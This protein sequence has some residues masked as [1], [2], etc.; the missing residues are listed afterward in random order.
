M[1]SAEDA[2]VGRI[3]FIT[4]SCVGDVVMSTPV[5]EAVHER[6]PGAR[7]DVVADSRASRLLARCP[8]LGDIIHKDKKALFR[9]VIGLM[10]QLR[11][12]RYDLIV[13]LRTDGLTWLLRSDYK[14][15]KRRTRPYGPH[16][17]ERM[18]GV[19]RSL[20]GEAPIPPAR[21]WLDDADRSDATE[22]LALLPQGAW[23][24]LGPGSAGA[25]ARKAWPAENYAALA[26][27]LQHRFAGVILAGG[28]GERDLA[29]EIA[30]HL[31]LPCIDATDTDLLQLAALLERSSLYVGADSG[32]GHIAAAMGAPTLTLFGEDLRENCLPWGGRA[33]GLAAASGLARDIPFEEVLAGARTLV[34]R[35]S[36]S[37]KPSR[38]S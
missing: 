11:G 9:G 4:L 13:D 17:V 27:S 5:L 6:Y 2:G 15:T 7:I 22:R 33:T 28:P 29:S 14:L 31:N 32:P 36:V 20:H 38:D 37:D 8:Y 30:A 12:R 18:M 34:D 26:N 19:I 35:Q 25:R 23:L 16:S 24:A 3:L 1:N 21:V 10:K